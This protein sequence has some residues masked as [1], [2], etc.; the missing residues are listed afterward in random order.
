M[1]K[2]KTIFF[3]I[4]NTLL[5]HKGAEQK[6]L[7]KIREKY[8]PDVS[9]NEFE[10]VWI[11]ETKKNWKLFE[12]KKL[13]FEKQ[14][15]QRITDVWIKFG[16]KIT[17]KGVQK[18]FSEY[19]KFYEDSWKSFPKVIETLSSILNS[20]LKIGIISNGDRNQQM[21]KLQQINVY[22]LIQKDLLITSGDLKVSKPNTEI[23]IF[24]QK[25]SKNKPEEIMMVGD[26]L[27]QDIEPATKLGWKTFHID[28]SGNG[29]GAIKNLEGLLI[30]LK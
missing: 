22:S 16:K 6:A 4:D 28:H 29:N 7:F 26:T 12:E 3:D 15:T 24:A 10:T 25:I 14:R 8:F 17:K 18:I 23:F 13:T 27:E 5:D 21:K 20:G 30:T 9:E 19:L 2:I 1:G 11:T